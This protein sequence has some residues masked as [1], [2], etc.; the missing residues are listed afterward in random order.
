MSEAEYSALPDD[1]FDWVCPRCTLS[2]L[3]YAEVSRITEDGSD[4]DVVE[5]SVETCRVAMSD[6]LNA[7]DL[8][9][10]GFPNQ[11]V[12]AHLNIR[13]LFPKMDEIRN[14]PQGYEPEMYNLPLCKNFPLTSTVAY[15]QPP[16]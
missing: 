10:F 9:N 14:T 2:G 13:S 8:W 11:I 4:M 7:G 3:H 12:V 15:M 16:A 5:W 6:S 1:S